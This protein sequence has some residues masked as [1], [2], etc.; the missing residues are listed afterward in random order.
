MD[1]H[2]DTEQAVESLQHLG[3][4]EYEARAFV[5]LSRLPSGTAKDISEVSD[6]PRTR[7]YDAV[8]VL[9]ER[10]LVEIQHTNPQV[11][12]AVSVAEAVQTFLTEF[13][14]HIESLRDSLE[15]LEPVSTADST[16]KK[17]EVWSLT[18][19]TA[20][21]N[22]MVELIDE[23]TR[24][25]TVVIATQADWIELILGRLQAAQSRGVSVTVGTVSETVRQQIQEQLPDAAVFVSDL[26]WMRSSHDTE[27]QIGRLVLVD[28]ETILVS[29]SEAQADR[30]QA[31]FGRGFENGLVAIFRRLIATGMESADSS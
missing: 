25:V 14:S 11:F 17:H 19:S 20:I 13:E 23:A 6:I 22:R 21:T 8:R 4:R 1:N 29:S 16:E 18:G 3:L 28:G 2:S 10:G 30:E 27:P 15:E 12:R 7:V 26:E 5:A 24:E 9:E 31:V